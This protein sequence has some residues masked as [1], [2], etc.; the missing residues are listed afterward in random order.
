MIV[1]LFEAK[2]TSTLVLFATLLG[3]AEIT[4]QRKIAQ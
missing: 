4:F 3:Y 1:A 2:I